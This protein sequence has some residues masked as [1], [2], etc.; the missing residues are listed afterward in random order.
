MREVDWLVSG[1][2][3]DGVGWWVG[4]WIGGLFDGFLD[5]LLGVVGWWSPLKFACSDR[6]PFI[7]MYYHKKCSAHT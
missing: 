2:L 1:L 7:H 4:E 3:V 5:V 6:A